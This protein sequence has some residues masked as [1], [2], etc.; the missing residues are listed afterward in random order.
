MS[1]CPLTAL[2]YLQA[3]A[4]AAGAKVE[5]GG[6]EFYQ[7]GAASSAAII[8]F[9]DVWGWHS[10]RTRLMADDLTR[11]GY[12]VYVPKLLQPALEGGT[13]GDGLPPDFDLAER[14]GD[15]G[16]WVTQ[17]P[18]AGSV[19]PK[20][21]ALIAYAKEQGASTI[22]VVGCCW[23][24][25]AAF[26]TSAICADVVCGVIFHPSCQLEGM[27]GGKVEELC[28]RVQCPMYFLPA[29]GDAPELYGLEGSLTT[30][31]KRKFGDKAKT[32]LFADMSHGW[33]PRGDITVPEVKRDVQLAMEEASA[34][35]AEL[36]P[37]DALVKQL[38]DM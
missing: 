26:H 5:A 12:R 10:G 34:Y 31:L 16:P 3:D 23:G 9:P 38:A 1:C 36:M 11:G 13:D 19:Q 22:G 14:G 27:F 33:V 8:L 29:T 35:F 24:G 17:I 18:F 15:F 28:E 4:A 32:K 2:G 25:W 21:E 30:I 20:V 37:S 6:C 7:T